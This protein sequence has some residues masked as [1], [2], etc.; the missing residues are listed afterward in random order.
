MCVHRERV[1]AHE[2]QNFPYGNT[3]MIG[4]VPAYNL[5]RLGPSRIYGVRIDMNIIGGGGVTVR[6]L[7][8]TLR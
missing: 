1:Q 6:N 3:I 7:D 2:A 8:L 5:E 4:L